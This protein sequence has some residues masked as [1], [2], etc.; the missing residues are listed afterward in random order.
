MYARLVLIVFLIAL[1]V[2]IL[3]GYFLYFY[4]NKAINE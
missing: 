2:E 4:L 1:F 3:L